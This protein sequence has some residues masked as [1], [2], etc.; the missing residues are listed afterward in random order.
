[1]AGTPYRLVVTVAVLLVGLVMLWSAAPAWAQNITIT[2][3]QP[4]AGG[5]AGNTLAVK[6]T[7]ASVFELRSVRAQVDSR[8]SPLHVTTPSTWE[9]TIDLSG[10]ARGAHL[11]TVTATDVFSNTGQGQQTF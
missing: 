8:S 9:G 1:M 11:L 2:I 6:A 10:L 3:V 7:V 5:L 4:P